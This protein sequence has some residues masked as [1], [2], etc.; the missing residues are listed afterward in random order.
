MLSISVN[1]ALF[2]LLGTTYGG[3]GRATFALPDLRGRVAIGIGQGKGTRRRNQHLIALST[4]PKSSPRRVHAKRA[5]VR[6]RPADPGTKHFL[7]RLDSRRSALPGNYAQTQ[8]RSLRTSGKLGRSGS[9]VRST[10]STGIQ[11]QADFPGW[12][13]GQS[14]VQGWRGHNHEGTNPYRRE[15]RR[16]GYQ[17]CDRRVEAVGEI[18]DP[19]RTR[20]RS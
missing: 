4:L 12:K 9:I 15:H 8:I 16:Y 14:R 7:V 5:A 6:K 3:D 17:R 20:T 10:R 2:S 11:T 18:P 13:D 1:T 19:G